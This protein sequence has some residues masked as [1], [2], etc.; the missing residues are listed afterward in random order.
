MVEQKVD[1]NFNVEELIIFIISFLVLCGSLIDA[2]R[3]RI[4]NHILKNKLVQSEVNN[5]IYTL[6]MEKL[7]SERDV[8]NVE[9]T[10]GFLKFISESRD[11]AFDY[12]EDAQNKLEAVYEDIKPLMYSETI[13]DSERE[14]LVVACAVILGLLPKNTN[15]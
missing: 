5:V 14:K 13:S 9:Q 4:N 8:Y 1:I 2:I 11:W 12:I 10:D 6:Q 7:V 15:N 3:I